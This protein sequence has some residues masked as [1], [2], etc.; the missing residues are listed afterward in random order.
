MRIVSENEA[1]NSTISVDFGATASTDKPLSNLVNGTLIPESRVTTSASSFAIKFSFLSSIELDTLLIS[2][3]N[4]PDSALITLRGSDTDS[5]GTAVT[6]I[7]NANIDR[8]RQYLAGTA[9]GGSGTYQYWW[10]EMSN[11][12]IGLELILGECWL[13]K[14]TELSQNP[15]LNSA[16]NSLTGEYVKLQTPGG[17]VYA[18][19][20]FQR[21]EIPLKWSAMPAT[22]LQFFKD[23]HN[24]LFPQKPCWIDWSDPSQTSDWLFCRYSS[25]A[26]NETPRGVQHYD[27]NMDFEEIPEPNYY[28]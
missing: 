20:S 18:N 21:R 4:I 23:L 3:H 16:S 15:T 7:T 5:Y 17:N 22:D 1:L 14:V 6:V 26:M 28:V 10:L 19:Q 9:S 13:T 27:F 8:I 11:L 24:L 2:G 25:Q 12:A